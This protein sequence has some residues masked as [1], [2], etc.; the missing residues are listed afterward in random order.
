ML[1]NAPVQTSRF[2]TLPPQ[3]D[4]SV[5]TPNFQMSLSRLRLMYCFTGYEAPLYCRGHAVHTTL[6]YLPLALVLGQVPSKTNGAAL[7]WPQILD[8][9]LALYSLHFTCR[10]V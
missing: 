2:V 6:F 5:S 8:Y 7:S 9:P 10:P 1:V 4:T 3:I